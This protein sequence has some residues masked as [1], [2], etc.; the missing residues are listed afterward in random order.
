MD[1]RKANLVPQDATSPEHARSLIALDGAAL[2]ADVTSDSPAVEIAGEIIGSRAVDVRPQFEVTSLAY[3][4][5]VRVVQSQPADE[6]GRKRHRASL[7]EHQPAHNDGFGFGDHAPDHLFLYCEKPCDLGGA[8]FLVDALRLVSILSA[9]DTDFARFAWNTPIDHSMPNFPFGEY[10][11]IAR[12]VPGGRVQVR[13]HPDQVTSLDHDGAHEKAM[14][15]KWFDAVNT[16]RRRGGH[17]RLE[18]GEMLCVDNY[19]MLHG[20]NGVVSSDRRMVSIWGW[21]S[22]AVAIPE[23]PIDLTQP[24]IDALAATR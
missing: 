12:V 17:I 2:V 23:G 8:S 24:D 5:E 20:R 11:P 6:R 16:A 9:D 7:D 22:D 14:L 1:V 21:S 3:A 18:A 13:A 4:E 15:A 19:R 10:W